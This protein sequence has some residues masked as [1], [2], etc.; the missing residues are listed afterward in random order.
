MVV[1]NVFRRL[2]AGL[3]SPFS[4]IKEK[5]GGTNPL[6]LLFNDKFTTQTSGGFVVYYVSPGK[7]KV[8][9]FKPVSLTERSQKDTS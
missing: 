4:T 7:G 2:L 1:I 6:R 8:T 3:N 5:N 9:A